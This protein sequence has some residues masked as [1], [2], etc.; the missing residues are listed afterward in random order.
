VVMMDMDL[1]NPKTSSVFKMNGKKG[2]AEF[3]DESFD[4]SCIVYSTE[5]ENL[6]VIPAGTAEQNATE[7]MLHGNLREL[8]EYLE[9]AFDY[10]IMDAA[11]VDPV[12]DAYVLS[13][14]VTTTLYVVRHN[15]TPET[16]VEMLDQNSK[17]KTLKNLAIVFNGI[18]PRGILMKGYG[19]GYGYG[20]NNVYGNKQYANK[21]HETKA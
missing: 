8:M 14:F 6:F 13:E 1:R 4:P 17:V 5:F 12:T 20:Y 10:I 18:K 2:M 9:S 21:Q 3:L 19:Y 16:M 11:P 7:L 15:Y